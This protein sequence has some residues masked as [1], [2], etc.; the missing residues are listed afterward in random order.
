V[1]G[2]RKKTLTTVFLL[3]DRRVTG[4]RPCV[5]GEIVIQMGGG[6]TQAI[7][8]IGGQIETLASFGGGGPYGH[9]SGL[10]LQ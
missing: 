4:P 3:N 9:V 6:G 5:G 2:G 10:R 1:G 8:S 7:Q